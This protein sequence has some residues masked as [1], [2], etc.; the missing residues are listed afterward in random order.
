MEGGEALNG[1]PGMDGL[2]LV[3]GR[4]LV[5]VEEMEQRVVMAVGE[6]H[7]NRIRGWKFGRREYSDGKSQPICTEACTCHLISFGVC[8]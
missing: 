8:I 7:R 3:E 2:E 5:S 1:D 6:L 4:A